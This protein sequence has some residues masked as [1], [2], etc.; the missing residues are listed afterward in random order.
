MD[1]Q[2]RQDA[3]DAAAASLTGGILTA[4][5]TI[6]ITIDDAHIV[7]QG[8]YCPNPV[9]CIGRTAVLIAVPVRLQRTREPVG[10]LKAHYCSPC[11][12][13]AVLKERE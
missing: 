6:G 1:E 4:G 3:L 11:R 9:P 8:H 2:T 5:D 7:E 10:E 12:T 13:M